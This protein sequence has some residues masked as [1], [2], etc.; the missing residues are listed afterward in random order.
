MLRVCVQPA[1]PIVSS[2]FSLLTHLDSLPHL[3]RLRVGKG[4]GHHPSLTAVLSK[5]SRSLPRQD[6]PLRSSPLFG[7]LPLP[8]LVA[9]S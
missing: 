6:S 8:G 2:A 1:D 4:R 9:K 5:P 7:G 3:V